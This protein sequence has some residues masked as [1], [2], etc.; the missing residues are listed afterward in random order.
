MGCTQAVLDTFSFQAESFYA[1]CAYRT[2]G[3]ADDFPT[4]HHRAYMAKQPSQ[5]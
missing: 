3:R 2:F 4:G 1:A 5:D